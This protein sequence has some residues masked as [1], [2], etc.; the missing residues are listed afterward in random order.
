MIPCETRLSKLIRSLIDEIRLVPEV[1]EM[2]RDIARMQ[3]ASEQSEEDVS[4][5]DGWLPALTAN[6][7]YDQP[8][9]AMRSVGVRV[10]G[11]WGIRVRGLRERAINSRAGE[12]V[13][14]VSS[15]SQSEKRVSMGG[16]PCKS[17]PAWE[18]TLL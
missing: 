15:P 3:K 18:I 17:I 1:D 6:E 14:R 5:P 11:Y 4:E 13:A 16:A 9:G 10:Q 2:I 12:G 8:D 7:A